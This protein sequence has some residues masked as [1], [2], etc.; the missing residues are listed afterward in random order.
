MCQNPSRREPGGPSATTPRTAPVYRLLYGGR[1]SINHRSTTIEI[2]GMN[3]SMRVSPPRI[4]ATA[5]LIPEAIYTM[6]A[7][8]FE[9]KTIAFTW[10]KR[11]TKADSWFWGMG[12]WTSSNPEYCLLGMKGSPKREAKNIHSIIDTIMSKEL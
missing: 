12:W 10:V 1:S 4:S 5:P 7:W 3:V 2:F 6:K 11:N 8:G 9:Y